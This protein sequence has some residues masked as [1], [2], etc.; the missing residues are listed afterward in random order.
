VLSVARS[1]TFVGPNEHEAR[2]ALPTS[3]RRARPSRSR[4]RSARSRRSSSPPY[5]RDLEAPPMATRRRRSRRAAT[6]GRGG[7]TR[8]RAERGEHGAGVGI[9]QFGSGLR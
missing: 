7:G 3:H 1:V 2:T 9:P 6:S 5:S 8:S 4:R